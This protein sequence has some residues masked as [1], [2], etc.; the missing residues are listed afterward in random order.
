MPKA[1]VANTSC[2]LANFTP[3]ERILFFLTSR[4]KM[5]YF[6]FGAGR[7]WGNFGLVWAKCMIYSTVH[8][9]DWKLDCKV[10]FSYNDWHYILIRYEFLL[11]LKRKFFILKGSFNGILL[12]EKE[13]LLFFSS[14]FQLFKSNENYILNIALLETE[15]ILLIL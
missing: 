3:V 11:F 10:H 9:L 4:P 12:F 8:T 15:V 1:R 5:P 6:R 14:K 7:I 2:G 13:I